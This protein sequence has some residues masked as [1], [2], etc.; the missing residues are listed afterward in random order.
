MTEKVW[1][2]N[3]TSQVGESSSCLYVQY[4]LKPYSSSN[5]DS[6]PIA[7][8]GTKPLFIVMEQSNLYAIKSARINEYV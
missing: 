1:L 5:D 6:S 8:S 2:K 7:L 4:V 3:G